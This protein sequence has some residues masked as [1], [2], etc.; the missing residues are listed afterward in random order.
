MQKKERKKERKK[1]IISFPQEFCLI[2][3]NRKNDIDTYLVL[4]D[5]PNKLKTNYGIDLAFKAKGTAEI[6]TNDRRLIQLIFDNLKYI[7]AK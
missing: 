7:M 5:F 3:K 2:H 4:V 1:E 6:I